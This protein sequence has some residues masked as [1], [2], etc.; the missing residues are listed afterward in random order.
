MPQA[1]HALNGDPNVV[2]MIDIMLVLLIVFILLAANNRQAVEMQLPVP[3]TTT[4]VPTP[5]IV[6]EVTPGP[7]Y[8]LNRQDV[9]ADQLASR[10][11]AVFAGRPSKIL[12]V[13]GDPRVRYQDVIAA[14]DVARGAGVRVS[15]VVLPSP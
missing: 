14:F 11:T 7:R 9:A 2:P 6:L 12:F 15:G 13:K 8:T 3:A 10:I 1:S 5:P 4:E